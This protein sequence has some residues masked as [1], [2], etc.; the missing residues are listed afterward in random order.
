M[1]RASTYRTR[2]IVASLSAPLVTAAVATLVLASLAGVGR[3][4]RSP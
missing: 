2:G 3:A 1:E 4:K